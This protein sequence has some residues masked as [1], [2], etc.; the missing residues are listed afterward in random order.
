MSDQSFF[1][2]ESTDTVVPRLSMPT[3]GYDVG[4]ADFHVALE[5]RLLRHDHDDCTAAARAALELL[6]DPDPRRPGSELVASI[7]YEAV[8]TLVGCSPSSHEVS[9]W[10]RDYNRGWWSAAVAAANEGDS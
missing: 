4:Y 1:D 8:V 3:L 6:S 9:A 2:D 10:L 7:G 5:Q